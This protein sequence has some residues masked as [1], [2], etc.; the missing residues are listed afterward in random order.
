MT[1]SLRYFKD[2]EKAPPPAS[3][4]NSAGKHARVVFVFERDHRLA[5]DDQRMFGEI[6]LVKDVDEFLQKARRS[7][8]TRSMSILRNS[9]TFSQNIAAR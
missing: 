1:G 9:K 6:G 3:A 4:E 2:E 5:F 7:A 8:R